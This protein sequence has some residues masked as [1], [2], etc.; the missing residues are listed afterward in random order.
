MILRKAS[1][2]RSSV[3]VLW[4]VCLA[5]ITLWAITFIANVW[6]TPPGAPGYPTDYVSFWTAGRLALNGDIATI[7]DLAAFAKQQQYEGFFRHVEHQL[8][9]FYPPVWLLYVTPLAALPYPLSFLA[10]VTIG[11]VLGAYL[12]FQC[13]PKSLAIAVFL[14]SPATFMNINSG[15]NG[16]ISLFLL[17]YGCHLSLQRR[18]IASG[19]Y[20]GL[21]I[22]KPHLGILIPFALLAARKWKTFIAAALTASFLVIVSSLIFGLSAWLEFFKSSHNATGWLEDGRVGYWRIAS[23]FSF[24]RLYGLLGRGGLDISGDLHDHRRH[25]DRLSICVQ[26]RSRDE[27]RHFGFRRI[28]GGAVFS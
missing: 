11:T 14:A 22:Y 26:T 10:F 1:T 5:L 24:F 9:F 15:Q 28:F 3:I 16:L 27:F 21:L 8:A 2:R 4:A 6:G 25:P 19:I 12:I 23:I 13:F 17:G 7:Y 20:F 18:E